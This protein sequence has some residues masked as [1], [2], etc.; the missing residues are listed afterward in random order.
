MEDFRNQSPTNGSDPKV[1]S[2]VAYVPAVGWL[3][4]L[5]LNNPKSELGSFHV[6]QALGIFLLAVVARWVMVI[7]FVGWIAGGAGTLLAVVLWILGAL[8]AFQGERKLV[9][10]LGESFQEWFRSL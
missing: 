4:A 1:V 7:P 5:I 3:I 10:V 6:R 2:L 8:S 9:P